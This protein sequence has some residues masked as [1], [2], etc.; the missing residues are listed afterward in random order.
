MT[1]FYAFQLLVAGLCVGVGAVCS[2]PTASAGLP[3][4][5]LLPTEPLTAAPLAAAPQLAPPARTEP[6]WGGQ[7]SGATDP[8]MLVTTDE[9]TALLEVGRTHLLHFELDEAEARFHRLAELEPDGPAAY[10]HLATIALWR[11]LVTEDARH[12]DAFFAWS[13]RTEEA[14][15]T[16]PASPWRGLLAAERELSRATAHLK[17]A[18]YTRAA[19]AGRAAFRGFE[20]VA[21]DHPDFHDVYKGLGLCHVAVGSVPKGYRW[22]V[23]L[24]GFSGTVQQG[25]DEL[26]RAASRSVT[27]QEEA[28]VALAITDLTLNNN[29]R[30][31]LRY[32][33]RLHRLH[34]ESALVN[35]LYGYALLKRRRAADAERHFRIG[36]RAQQGGTVF[37]LAYTRYYLG[38]ALYRQ[39]RFADAAAAF[40][41]YLSDFGG[42]ALRARAHLVAGLAREMNGQ[43]D[44]ALTHYR[45]VRSERD[46]DTDAAAL[47]EAQRRIDAPLSTAER[48]LLRGGNAFDGGRYDEAVTTLQ[49]LLAPDAATP[50]QY[51]E[52]AYRSGRAFHEDGS[53]REALRH[54]AI[55][56][57]NPGDPLARW[58]PWSQF[59]A[60]GVHEQQGRGAEARAAYEAVLR[61]DDPFDYHRALEQRA[62]A[63]LDRLDR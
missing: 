46:F 42:E 30:G 10:H 18:Q 40:E 26:E 7:A 35:H 44:R 31:G 62:R 45:R 28:L 12:F 48:L 51:A 39:N 6:A 63:A 56:I 11:G 16:A 60:G 15:D 49:P 17:L 4:A 36:L 55:A 38:D 32:M 9:G 20:R 43:R 37:P 54:Y 41:R 3:G 24:A 27:Q 14:L 53:P 21:G 50:V 19:I 5:L 29:R 2:A 1:H 34:P 59:Y 61:Y 25:M 23:K 33:E 13:D 58:G 8:V 52:A 57:A 47:R 22:L